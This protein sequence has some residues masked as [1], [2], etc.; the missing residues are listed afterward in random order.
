[1]KRLSSA[2]DKW[3]AVQEAIADLDKYYGSDAWKQ[4]LADDEAGRLPEGLKRGVL[5]EDSIWN[6]LT[7]V[8]DLNTRLQQ[9]ATHLATK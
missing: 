3:E 1:M 9:L 6:L 4:D 7:D 2:L 8:H 5:S